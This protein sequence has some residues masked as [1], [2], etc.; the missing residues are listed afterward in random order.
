MLGASSLTNAFGPIEAAF[1]AANPGIDVV[2]TFD[3]S[4]TLAT[5][6]AEGAPADVLAT[7]D[8]ATMA[9][10]VDS[11]AVAGEPVLFATNTGVLARP[12]GNDTVSTPE[13]LTDD[14][15]VLAVCTPEVPCGVVAAEL[16][17]AVGVEAS[18]DSEEENVSAVLTKLEADEVDAGVIY[19]TDDLASDA[20][21]AVPLPDGVVVTTDYPI[22]AVSDSDA[23][24]AFV[25]FVTGPE[26]RALLTAAGFIEP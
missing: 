2:A 8:E 19:V 25:E 23:A 24:T 16:F 22:A 9:T 15:V 4:S 21:E 13:D 14:D 12:V 26:G 10:A 7:A 6:V 5:Q 18:V 3:S 17:A 1:E 20:V 11:G